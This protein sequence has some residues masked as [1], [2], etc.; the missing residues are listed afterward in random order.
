MSAVIAVRDVTVSYGAE[1]Q[2]RDVLRNVDLTIEAGSF[3]CF[4]G[5][6]GCGKTT[7]LNVIAGI[8]PYTSGSLTL[9]GKPIDD[10]SNRKRLGY[11]F[12]DHR[13]LPWRTALGNAAFVLEAWGV[14]RAEREE[15]AMRALRLVGLDTFAGS[16]PHQLSGGM[17]SRVA[18]ARALA[19]EP[20]VLLMDEPFGALDAQTRRNLQEELVRVWAQQGQ[21]IVFVTHDILEAIALAD[22]IVLLAP[23]AVGLRHIQTVALP[24]PRRIGDEEVVRMFAQLSE[25]IEE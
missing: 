16:Y 5:R 10:A 19:I 7:L 4:L 11:V 3:T 23:N 2:R 1:K 15:R 24:R 21:T 25:M 14:A 6:S 12:Q 13:L 18:L 20:D 8:V 22:R 9:D 17:R